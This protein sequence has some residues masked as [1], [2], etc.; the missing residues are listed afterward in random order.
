M[1]RSRDGAVGAGS[2]PTERPRPG[3]AI[4][5]FLRLILSAI[6]ALA[7]PSSGRGGQGEPA[8]ARPSTKPSDTSANSGPPRTEEVDTV[9][10]RAQTQEQLKSLETASTPGPATTAGVG[11]RPGSSP[12]GLS[13]SP[14][15]SAMDKQL[16]ELLQGR[17][18]LAG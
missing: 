2:A 18:A 6:V 13:A 3:S 7:A 4:R 5:L 11:P 1:P 12:T 10:L 15:D 14:T 9:A 17:L 16:R 8:Q